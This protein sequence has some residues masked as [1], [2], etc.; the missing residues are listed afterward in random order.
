[1]CVCVHSV[2][3]FLLQVSRSEVFKEITLEVR[4][5]SIEAERMKK[6]TE[7]ARW[8]LYT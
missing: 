1:M 3:R 8:M 2:D 6:A 7:G 5:S 4:V